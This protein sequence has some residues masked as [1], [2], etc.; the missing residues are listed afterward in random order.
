M[1]FQQLD[2][3]KMDC[4]LL[5][6]RPIDGKLMN[7]LTAVFRQVDDLVALTEMFNIAFNLD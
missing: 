5:F 4:Q 1:R 7:C 2:D 6:F 3:F